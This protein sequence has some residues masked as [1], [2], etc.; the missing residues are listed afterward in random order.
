VSAQLVVETYFKALTTGD[1]DRLIGLISKADH[2]I[3]IGTDE[4]EVVF[5]GS[6]A[7]EYYRDH[8][9]STEE[10]TIDIKTLQ[11]QERETIAWFFTEQTWNLKWRGTTEEHAMRLT[12]VLQIEEDAWKFVQIHA[13]V[14]ISD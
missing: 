12:G 8:V 6:N 1:L 7:P 13:S 2:F 5:G 10:F 14:G 9:A 4:N 3:K 11:V